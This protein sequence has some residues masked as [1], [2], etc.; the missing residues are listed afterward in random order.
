MPYL[1]KQRQVP[2]PWEAFKRKALHPGL[3]PIY[4]FNWAGEWAAY[5][6]GKWSLFEVL[7]YAGSLSIL[8]AVIFYFMDSGN[9]VKQKHYQAWQVIN[10][11]QGKGG[12]GG[13]IEALQELNKD[14]VPL[15]GVDV[16]DAYLQDLKLVGSDLR[17]S[18][19]RG[20]DLRRAVFTGSNLEG[21]DLRSA[22]LR[23]GTLDS[24]NLEDADLAD[25]DLTGARLCG[26]D[27]RGATLEDADLSEADLTGVIGW[28]QVKSVR[29]ANI[30][31]LKGAPAGFI[32]WARRGGASDLPE[33]PPSASHPAGFAASQ[34]AR[35]Q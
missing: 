15:V 7:E 31:G 1:V 34:P 20:S 8:F 24:A 33:S 29:G 6:L 12:S 13:R 19:F 14:G 5:A 32:A 21:S 26:A 3:V 35:S 10:T 30:R 18:N 27:L 28:E 4:W 23:G 2:E 25:I 16:A 22:N 17:R 9:R 11:A